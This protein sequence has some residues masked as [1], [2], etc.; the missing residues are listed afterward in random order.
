MYAAAAAAQ[1]LSGW[2]GFS[3]GLLRDNQHR[4][5]EMRVVTI[6]RRPKR[7]NVL[8]DIR[9]RGHCFAYCY[10][11]C[12]EFLFGHVADPAHEQAYARTSR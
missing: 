11:C 2:L 1:E 4:M 9:I 5:R 3:A 10:L 7:G 12:D 8:Q 6:S